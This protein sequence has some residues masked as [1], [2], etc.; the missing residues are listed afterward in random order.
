MPEKITCQNCGREIYPAY[1]VCPHCNGI[2]QNQGVNS[3]PELLECPSCKSSFSAKAVSCPQCSSAKPIQCK[4]CSQKIPP[5]SEACPE[6]GDPNPFGKTATPNQ[7][8]TNGNAAKESK[9]TLICSHCGAGSD[10]SVT[11]YGKKMPPCP[12]C[13]E[14]LQEDKEPGEPLGENG[15]DVSQGPTSKNYFLQHWKGE[16]SLARSYWLNYVAIGFIFQLAAAFYPDKIVSNTVYQLYIFIFFSFLGLTVIIWQIVGVWRSAN[17]HIQKTKRK[18]WAVTAKGIMILGVVSFM[19]MLLQLLPVYNEIA[20]IISGDKDH[21]FSIKL[22]DNKKEVEITGGIK[23]GLTEE[24]RKD[25]N[26]YSTIK[27]IH[28]N[29]YGGRVGEARLLREF[30]EEKGLATS[31]TRGCFSACT[32]AYM[33]GSSRFVYGEKK[34]G[35]H[36]YSLA[37]NETDFIKQAMDDSLKEDME[38]FVKKGAS[39]EFVNK[40]FNT[41]PADLWFPE[42]EVLFSNNIITDIAADNDFLL[43]QKTVSA[44]YD[45]IDNLLKD[46]P[47]FPVIKEYYP[48][49]Y[50]KI[51]FKMGMD[52]DA[53]ISEGGQE[54]GEISSF[55]ASNIEPILVSQLPYAS[56]DA[57]IEYIDIILEIGDKLKLIDPS[58]CYDFYMNGLTDPKIQEYLPE[59]DKTKFL[60]MLSEILRSSIEN[61]QQLPT[62][63]DVAANVEAI[64]VQLYSK[65]GDEVYGWFDPAQVEE[66]NEE[67]TCEII[68]DFFVY[69]KNFP[70]NRRCQMLRYIFAESLSE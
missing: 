8:T 6:C 22:L 48:E 26:K 44:F 58:L 42:N 62:E 33:G 15:S 20:Q 23:F 27:V 67:K 10:S 37:D 3:K 1:A 64:T 35:F 60:A 46:I 43:L 45:D 61:P 56:D 2:K 34:L 21:H 16:H 41:P 31:T 14:L 54:Y 47:V 70:R 4:I 28:L 9:K 53:G 25:L 57:L 68:K 11:E 63:T 59:S 55:I 32:I 38:Y 69:T 50:N 17:R 5:D 12:E 30:I 66:I 51:I 19:Y 13:G 52:I 40:I 7:V 18:F 24:L 49:V 39:D 65:Y 36:Q 29:S